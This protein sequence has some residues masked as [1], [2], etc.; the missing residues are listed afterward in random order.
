[1]EK[2]TFED[3]KTLVNKQIDTI[4][5]GKVIVTVEEVPFETIPNGHG[6]A[7][8]YKEKDYLI[9]S[10]YIYGQ[11]IRIKDTNYPINEIISTNPL[12]QSE[13]AWYFGKAPIK[14]YVNDFFS[15]NGA[16][17]ENKKTLDDVLNEFLPLPDE[18][19]IQKIKECLQEK[20]IKSDKVNFD[21]FLNKYII[22]LDLKK[23]LYLPNDDNKNGTIT[24]YKYM[25]LKTYFSMLESQSFRMNSIVS[26]NDKEEIFYMKDLIYG[27]ISKRVKELRYKEIAENKN[28]LISSFSNKKDDAIM[29]RLY[30][31]S[32]NGVCLGFDVDKNNVNKIT[33]VSSIKRSSNQSISKTQERYEILREIVDILQKDD[34]HIYFSGTDDYKGIVKSS[35]YDMENEYRISYKESG[36][37]KTAFYEDNLICKYKDFNFD[38]KNKKFE[39]IGIKPTNLIIGR[40]IDNFETNYPLLVSLTSEVFNLNDNITLSNITNFR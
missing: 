26:M 6:L 7:I 9:L 8:K 35:I 31:N 27:D 34:I 11:Q 4:N 25:P 16:T 39:K 1:M 19:K 2:K 33:Y 21:P 14:I 37:Y 10:F 13:P 18:Q 12:P 22:D 36:E 40:N 29:W 23:I 3:L 17:L 5:F 20:D 32:G 30:G 28:N 24:L 38:I 15:C